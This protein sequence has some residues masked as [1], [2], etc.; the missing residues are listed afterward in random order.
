M[1]TPPR[2]VMEDA[3]QADALPIAAAE[4][5]IADA[6]LASL[7]QAREELSVVSRE[8]KDG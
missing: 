6:L 1:L 2:R 7:A 4:A 8:P 5:P 3:A